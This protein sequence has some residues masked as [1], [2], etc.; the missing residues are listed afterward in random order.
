VLNRKERRALGTSYWLWAFL[1]GHLLNDA[2]KRIAA[3]LSA[4]LASGSLSRSLCFFS[5]HYAD[6]SPERRAGN[7]HEH[8]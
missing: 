5:L 1:P 2:I 7:L 6:C 4:N 8:R 3:F